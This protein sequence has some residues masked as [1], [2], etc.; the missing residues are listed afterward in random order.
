MAM[1]PHEKEL[2]KLLAEKPFALI[3]I[4]SDGDAKKVNEILERENITWRNVIDGST[5]GP[6]ATSWNVRGWPTIYIIDAK[7]VIRYK[8][9]RDKQMEEAVMKLLEEVPSPKRE[10]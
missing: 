4:N 1:L 2:V 6:I 3:G 8:N 5:D 10:K 9:L 7:G